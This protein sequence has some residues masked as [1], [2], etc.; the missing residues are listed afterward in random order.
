MHP[1]HARSVPVRSRRR[2]TTAPSLK[3][4]RHLLLLK[5]APCARCAHV[6]TKFAC[7]AAL[8]GS[9]RA[10]QS[11]RRRTAR[12]AP[13]VMSA[14]LPA[15]HVLI[16]TSTRRDA[17][18]P[19][20]TFRLNFAHA[21]CPELLRPES[22]A[23]QTPDAAPSQSS[24]PDGNRLHRPDPAAGGRALGRRRPRAAVQAAVAADPDRP[25]RAARVAAASACTSR[26]IR[27][28]S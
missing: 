14:S 17:P 24:E 15:A 1:S 20:A 25:R 27:K 10:S 7:T 18:T 16:G 2:T 19:A 13:P 28:S 11:R 26:S 6:P 3:H 12:G 8:D 22:P 4:V 23:V 21:R 9:L 5:Q